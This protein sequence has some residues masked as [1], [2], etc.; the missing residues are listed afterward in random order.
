MSRESAREKILAT[1]SGLFYEHGFRAVGVDTIIEESGVA[2]MSLYRHFPSKDDLILAYLQTT[3]DNMIGWMNGLVEPHPED[4]KAA[5]MA[6][7]EGLADLTSQ[8]ACHGCAFL[9]AASEFPS[10]Q[11]PAHQIA[12]AYKQTNLEILQRLAQ[13]AGAVNPLQLSQ[14]LFLLMDGALAAVRVFGPTNPSQ[15]LVSATKAL[16]EA[17][18]PHV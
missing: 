16:L 18:L 8:G 3:Y 14:Q 9:L 7:F 13:Q 1:A 12:L 4:G 10:Q 5:I 11:H 6:L 2:K 15:S 17:S